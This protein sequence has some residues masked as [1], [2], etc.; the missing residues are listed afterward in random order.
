M[1]RTLVVAS[2][3]LFA[4][5]QAFAADCA[6]TI[7]STDQMTWDTPAIEVSK[8]CE[9]FSVT[10][11]HSGT[12]ASN[13]MG[14]NWVLT[15]AADL[16]ATA[17][18]G[19]A[20]GLDKDYVK[21]DDERVIAHTKIIGGGESDTVTFSVS[22]LSEGEEYAYFCSFPGHFAMMRGTLTLVD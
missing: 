18:D 4:G 14:H 12:L 10:L 16:Q 7:D 3:L 15:K 22:D 5:T 1:I 2:T 13:V 21:P 17:T 20:E 9:E 6:V 11:H 19:M 8:S